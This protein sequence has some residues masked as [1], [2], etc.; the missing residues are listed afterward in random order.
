MK[1]VDQRHLPEERLATMDESGKR[2]YIF[3]ADVKGLYRRYRT[4]VQIVLVV[5]FLIL[6]WVKISG[7]QALLLDIVQRRFSIFGLTFWAHD[8]PLIFFILA[9]LTIG[10]GFIT[11]LW[12]RVW[13]G[14]AC[15]Q[16]VFIDG[17]FR[18]IEYWVIGSHIK[19]M[20]LAK[21]PWTWEK[22]IRYSITWIL[23]TAV[24]LI[25]THSFLAYFVGAE[26]LVDMTQHNPR[27]NW[28]VF[29]I[30][31][32]ITAVLLFDFGWFREQFCIIMC[33]YGRF[34]S[35]LMDD[36]S[37]TVSYDPIRGEPRRG[38]A[39]PGGAEGDCINCYKCVAVCPTGI[40]IRNGLQ[41]ECI[42]CTAC[43]DACDEVMEKIGKPKG[44][45]RY[46]TGNSLKGIKSSMFRP[47]V[48]IYSVML[49][50]VVALLVINISRREDIVVTV[51]RGTDTPYQIVKGE[52][53]ENNGEEE[54]QIINHFKVHLKNQ[55]FDDVRLKI[56]IPETWK[57]KH[58]EIISQTDT[59][60]LD[61][62]KD[63]T[64]HFFVK[65][66]GTITAITGE[67]SV[68]IIFLDSKT[69]QI[70]LEKDLNL[71]GP[72]SL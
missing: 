48:A 40:D 44:L 4:I 11:A 60:N 7:H 36:D 57:E 55:T 12:G 41:M 65:F 67:Q 39:K 14:W 47:R 16:T 8:S 59:I 32:F 34:Q 6:P 37:L 70:K 20:N 56:A 5:F 25:I 3:P 10:L 50:V 62:G 53:K 54:E 46:A 43:I 42:G 45:I 38:F 22:F 71:V 29:L 69:N 1:V 17:V 52:E 58:V 9:T 18:R 30:M 64:V 23:F 31:A 35:V 51:L 68:K 66:P 27:E 13:C 24:S 19:Q 61:A 28:T 26:R 49:V 21:S 63:L 33:P 15:P 2:V 72:K